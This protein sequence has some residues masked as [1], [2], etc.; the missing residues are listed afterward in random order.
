MNGNNTGCVCLVG[1]GCGQADLITLRGLRR[2]AQCQVL[3]YDDLIDETLLTFA[4]ADA[5]KIYVGKR[6]GAHSAS[7]EEI[8][9]ILISHAQ[10]GKNVLRLKG[11]DP[12][13]FGRGGEELLALMANGIPFEVVPGITSAIGIP[14]AAGIP[15]THRGLS[16]SLHIITGHTS[17]TPDGLPKDLSTLAQLSGTLVFMMGLGHIEAIARQ[18]IS[19]GK[20]RNTPSA[21]ISGRNAPHPITIRGTLDTIADLTRKAQVQTPA[22]ILVGAV[23]ALDLTPQK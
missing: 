13:V 22:V 7:Q 23:A 19:A 16:Q 20:P 2:I 5:E 18:L 12:F 15:V 9:Q 1:A 11:G 14:A 8:N 21:V 4:P 17:D 3:V 10:A 6:A